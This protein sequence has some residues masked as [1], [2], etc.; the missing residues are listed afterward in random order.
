MKLIDLLYEHIREN[1][2]SGPITIINRNACNRNAWILFVGPMLFFKI[3][4]KRTFVLCCGKKRTHI[5][6][7]HFLKKDN[8]I[9][10]VCVNHVHDQFGFSR[11][12]YDFYH[13]DFNSDAAFDEL[14]Y[15]MQE[16]GIERLRRQQ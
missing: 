4:H 2:N 7:E 9:L 16:N 13:L 10:A 14:D 15:F 12:K 6:N 1:F 5:S 3:D 8:E 11:N